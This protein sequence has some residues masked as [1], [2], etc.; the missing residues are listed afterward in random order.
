MPPSIPQRMCLACRTRAPQEQLVRIRRRNDSWAVNDPG[1]PGRS[2][3]W[4]GQS[5][6]LD[7][8]LHG[9]RLAHAL[10]AEISPEDKAALLPEL[11]THKR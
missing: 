8:L 4:C 7:K 11:T 1:A 6:C 2:A 10:K 5:A 9:S 3:Y